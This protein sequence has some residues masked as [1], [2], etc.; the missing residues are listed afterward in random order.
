MRYLSVKLTLAFLLVSVL[1]ALL[2]A[3]LVN[4]Q[5]QRQFEQLVHDLYYDEMLQ[6]SSQLAAYYQ[7]NQNWEGISGVV[8]RDVNQG[9]SRGERT[10]YLPVTVVDAERRVVL[11]AR[12]YQ[13]GHQV[14]TTPIPPRPISWIE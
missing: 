13:P 14:L 4:W 2:V 1:G 5:T 3:F 12:D 10:H 11:G 9:P 8:I 6:A 7:V